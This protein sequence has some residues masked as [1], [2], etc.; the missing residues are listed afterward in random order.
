MSEFHFC[1][2]CFYRKYRKPT[3]CDPFTSFCRRRRVTVSDK[4]TCSLYHRSPADRFKFRVWDK[5]NCFFQEEDADDCSIRYDGLLSCEFYG[6]CDTLPHSSVPEEDAVIEMCIGLRDRCGNPIYEGDY[7][8]LG[9][10][11]IFGVVWDQDS[12]SFMLEIYDFNEGEFEA[13]GELCRLEDYSVQDMYVNGN[14]HEGLLN[15]G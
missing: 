6:D 13:S 2:S 5:K 14:I 8:V 11:D 7:L 4:G 12:A 15:H 10:I 1:E 9:G 3:L